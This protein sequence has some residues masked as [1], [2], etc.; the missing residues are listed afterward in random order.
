MKNC[1]RCGMKNP[2]IA[3]RCD[4]GYDSVS[5][6][7]EATYLTSGEV[8]KSTR[9]KQPS[10]LVFGMGINRDTSQFLQFIFI[11]SENFMEKMARK[12]ET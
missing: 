4:C 6:Q 8:G 5:G 12:A 3:Q 10:Q 1:P 9:K 7:Q 11:G 2:D